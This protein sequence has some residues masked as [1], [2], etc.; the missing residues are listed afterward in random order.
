MGLCAQ[1]GESAS[2]PGHGGTRHPDNSQLSHRR[3]APDARARE[4][5]P[6]GRHFTL[7]YG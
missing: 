6:L 3:T 7:I 1:R 5:D 4:R 2:D